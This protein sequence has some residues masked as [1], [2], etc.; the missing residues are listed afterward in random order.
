MEDDFSLE[1]AMVEELRKYRATDD[2]R[3]HEKHAFFPWA[4]SLPA[5][6]EESICLQ[7]RLYPNRNPE[8]DTC[9]RFLL[10]PGVSISVAVPMDAMGN[11]HE[12][13][14]ATTSRP[15]TAETAIFWGS[16]I[17]QD[18]RLEYDVGIKRWFGNKAA[19]SEECATQIRAEINTV[20][21]W[22]DRGLALIQDGAARRIQRAWVMSRKRR[23]A[24]FIWH[25][26][27]YRANSP[28]YGCGKR[29][30]FKRAAE[31]GATYNAATSEAPSRFGPLP[32]LQGP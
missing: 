21:R 10:A 23:A 32:Q 20:A 14:Q 24:R 11:R 4:R 29:M 16:H 12:D 7:M 19:S 13:L 6:V 15:K 30:F 1:L 31:A 28:H 27:Y 2:F 8:H 26:W 9:T 3:K 25:F 22:Y 18:P 5:C 17:T